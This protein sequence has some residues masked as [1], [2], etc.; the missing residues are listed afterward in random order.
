MR[1]LA[2]LSFVFSGIFISQLVSAEEI[3][4]GYGGLPGA[5]IENEIYYST[6]ED[7]YNDTLEEILDGLKDGDEDYLVNPADGP[8]RIVQTTA[9]VGISYRGVGFGKGRKHLRQV[10]AA[11]EAFFKFE[12]WC[13]DEDPEDRPTTCS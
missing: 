3:V 11:D 12:K 7:D 9:K 8:Y 5:S 10:S 1:K 6:S 4:I 13:E 2:T